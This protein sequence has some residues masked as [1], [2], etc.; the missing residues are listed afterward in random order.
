MNTTVG[1]PLSIILSPSL[2]LPLDSSV[3]P[4]Q[5]PNLVVTSAAYL[6]FYR[7]RSDHYLGGPFLEGIVAA[8]NNPDPESQ[9]ASRAPSP[10]GEGE[11]LG[12]FSR[13]G[14]SSA[15]LGAGAGHQAGGGGSAAESQ[16]RNGA[17]D[18]ELPSYYAVTGEQTL[19]GMDME[20][21]EG[22][23]GLDHGSLTLYDRPSWSFDNLNMSQI[24]AAP[25][26]SDLAPEEG[27]FDGASDQAAG[28]SSIGGL[29]EEGNRI[30]ADFGED[31][32][33]ISGFAGTPQSRM[34]TPVDDIPPPLLVD[35]EDDGPVA[36]VHLEEG[37]GLKMD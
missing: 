1:S 17:V 3:Y 35:D 4:K 14:S 31:Q 2:T 16:A 22:V 5:N 27:L 36:E 28:G 25:P 15:L 9:T 18:S 34:G 6:L 7:R 37:E 21:D 11:R 23:A 12:D 24:I 19:E 13:N 8:A 30:L 26:G 32:G 10:A 20:D 33:T 29:S